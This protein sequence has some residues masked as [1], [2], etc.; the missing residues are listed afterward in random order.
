MQ[1]KSWF[2]FGSWSVAA[3]LAAGS[4]AILT[5]GVSACSSKPSAGTTM[6][7][8]SP[9]V[10]ATMIPAPSPSTSTPPGTVASTT[11]ATSATPFPYQGSGS[12]SWSGQLTVQNRTISVSGTM[13]VAVDANGV[14]TGAIA[15][16]RGATAPTSITAKV[17][18]NGNLT[19]TVS[20][21]VSG[22]TFSTNW[23]GKMTASG[24]NLSMQGTWT[25][26]YGSG[27]FSGSG[28]S[29]K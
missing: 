7:S 12:G 6:P 14:F 28:T 18:S 16:S 15:D 13:T 23:Q 9:T 4:L 24:S 29:S 25:S 8:S 5:F 21:T 3:L 26:Q 10:A 19:G 2:L 27:T 17:E 11:V 20:F 1:M 22:I